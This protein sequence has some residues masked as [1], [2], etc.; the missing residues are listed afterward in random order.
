[1]AYDP[2]SDVLDTIRLQGAVFFLWEPAWPFGIG[3]ADGRKLSRH[4][5]IRSDCIVSYHIVT[6]GPCWAAVNGEDP[7]L[8]QTGDTLILPRGDAYKIASTPQYPTPEDESGSIAFFQSMAS[9]TSPAVIT[10]GGNGSQR[11]RLI[12]GFLGCNLGPFNPL[13]FSLPRMMC[14]PAPVEGDDPLSALITFALSEAQEFRGGERSLLMRLSEL[15]FVEIM[16]RHMRSPEVSS[17]GW[18]RA[19]RDPLVGRAL[20]IM[21]GD[22]AATWT[23]QELARALGISRSVFAAR[24]SRI[25]GIPPMQYLTRWRMQFAA[26]RLLDTSAK[27]IVVASEVGYDSEEAFSRAFKRVVG[28]SPSRWR[29][30]H[31]QTDAVLND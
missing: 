17:S 7:L 16:R 30:V 2:V 14:I 18:L 1:L 24:F 15:M 13:L 20:A 22:I 26:H 3:V 31:D 29:R 19:L 4:M 12:C 8:L 21:H 11:S 23:L 5:Q 9:N 25:V 27:M 6:E 28:V 10:E